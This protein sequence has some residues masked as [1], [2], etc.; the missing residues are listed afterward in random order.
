MPPLVGIRAV[1]SLFVCC[2]VVFLNYDRQK[3]AENLCILTSNYFIKSCNY[4]FLI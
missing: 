2:F 1:S 4:F 3:T